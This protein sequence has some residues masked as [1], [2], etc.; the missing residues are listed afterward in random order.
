MLLLLPACW[1][2]ESGTHHLIV[3]V[4]FGVIT[5]T[6]YQGVSVL[7]ST[8]AGGEIGP[9]GFGVGLMNHHE[10][11]IDP[12]IASNLVISVQSYPNRI[13]IT[14]YPV[15]PKLQLHEQEHY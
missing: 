8:I 15:T 12:E 6:N 13:I 11:Q 14:N 10:V 1:T 3:G 4:G 5:T 7:N 9:Y 2:N